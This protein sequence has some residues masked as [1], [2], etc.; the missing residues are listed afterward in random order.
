MLNKVILIGNL[1]KD[2][3]VRFIKDETAVCNFSIATVEKYKKSDGEKV[4]KTEWHNIVVWR[5]LAEIC[6]EY[7]R[8]GSL[9]YIEGSLTTRKWDDK[10]GATKYTT[11]IVAKEMKMLG[12]G[13]LGGSK[14]SKTSSSQSDDTPPDDDDVPF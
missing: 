3:E 9:V 10:D 11:E 2:P 14:S 6:G 7:L 13:G 8:K 12:G 4:E 5:K 1:G